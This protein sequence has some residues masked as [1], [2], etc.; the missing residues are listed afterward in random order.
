[1][2]ISEKLKSLPLH[3]R[4]RW[5]IFSHTSHTLTSH[6]E[7]LVSANLSLMIHSSWSG[8]E[9]S[10]NLAG[11]VRW[12]CEKRDI[13]WRRKKNLF[14]GSLSLEKKNKIGGESSYCKL[15]DGWMCVNIYSLHRY[16]SVSSFFLSIAAKPSLPKITTPLGPHH[17]HHHH[18]A[19]MYSIEPLSYEIDIIIVIHD[20]QKFSESFMSWLLIWFECVGS[21]QFQIQSAVKFCWNFLGG[22]SRLSSLFLS[23]SSRWS[24]AD[25]SCQPPWLLHCHEPSV[26]WWSIWSWTLNRE[27]RQPKVRTQ[28]SNLT[29]HLMMMIAPNRGPQCWPHRRPLS[30][31]MKRSQS[32]MAR[33]IWTWSIVVV[34]Y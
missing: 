24:C 13:R 32:W 6:F 4:F 11:R 19:C 1:M 16:M 12:N 5:Q 34:I 9:T 20:G 10:K 7:A 22:I 2:M 14:S 3:S 26:K 30:F 27:S 21:D 31:S 8:W 28:A 17:H 29:L 18:P 15:M 23:T 33:I 25:K